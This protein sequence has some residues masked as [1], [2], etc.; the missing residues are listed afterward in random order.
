MLTPR[1]KISQDDRF[2]EISIYAPFTHVSETEIF[3]EGTDFRFYSKPYFLR[4]HF[5]GE[6]EENDLASAKF[7]AETCSYLV[8]CSKV[9][10]GEFFKNLDMITELCKPKGSDKISAPEIEELD[11]SDDQDEESWYFDQ[12]ITTT[13][14]CHLRRQLHLMG[15]KP[16]AQQSGAYGNKQFFDS[17]AIRENIDFFSCP[18]CF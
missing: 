4:L 9:N 5:S 18:S 15:F 10:H 17:S 13:S 12:K 2:V 1:F 3:M 14:S 8:K 11:D 7:D 16:F 6:I